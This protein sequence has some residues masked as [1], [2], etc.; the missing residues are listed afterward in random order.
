VKVEESRENREELYKKLHERGWEFHSLGEKSD[1]DVEVALLSKQEGSQEEGSSQQIDQEF[2]AL[3]SQGDIIHPPLNMRAWA[4][5]KELSTRLSS[6]IDIMVR[7]TVG[8]GFDVVPN[9][10]AK[11]KLAQLKDQKR[12]DELKQLLGQIE[13]EQAAL[14]ELID[15]PNDKTSFGE[16]WER[17]Q[18]DRLAI[19]NGF[20]EVTRRA[21]GSM[22]NLFHVPGHT[23]RIRTKD[24][25][26]AQI[27]GTMK[28]YF[29]HFHDKRVFNAK[30]GE[31]HKGPEPLPVEDRATELIH[32]KIYTPRD[33]FYGLPKH[34]SSA[35]AITGNRLASEANVYFFDNN[36][37]PRALIL[38][39]NGQLD[40]ESFNL[41]EKFFKKE[42]KGVENFGRVAILQT[43]KKKATLGA[44][45][46]QPR[47][48]F[49][50]VSVGTAEEASWAA[51][52]KDNDEEIRQAFGIGKVFFTSED[53]N[54]S[55]AS[56]GRLITNEQIFI[57]DQIEL[58]FS[59]NHTITKGLGLRLV[60]M[61]FVRP[62]VGDRA[63]MGTVIGGL[64]KTGGVFP[65]DVRRFLGYEPV[66]EEWGEMPLQV[67]LAK[68]ALGLIG[69]PEQQE[70]VREAM[71]E[72]GTPLT[73]QNFLRAI[74]SLDEASGAIVGQMM[75]G[76]HEPE[77]LRN[78]PLRDPFE[79][80]GAGPD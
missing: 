29:K 27:R 57:P 41:L 72:A 10:A 71:K 55:S 26:Y 76:D 21:D 35:P 31:E 69:T 42:G 74:A 75:Q 8:L 5:Q 7:N 20:L 38:V 25:G 49:V 19:G 45:D 32:F 64:A 37:T 51:Y 47:I 22:M 79:L 17:V 11:R 65:N 13:T 60:E 24:R 80:V 15:P 39:Q 34:V 63:V 4:L 73:P 66:T 40:P 28:K 77:P 16:M 67:Y 14:L 48:D 36:A 56:V 61:Q 6:C 3:Y 53:V 46:Q 23:V 2:T 18:T 68:L 9:R 52:R 30:S 50:P 44:G 70:S 78:D 54:R 59:F 62:E 43:S 58:E 1:S 12:N 33:S